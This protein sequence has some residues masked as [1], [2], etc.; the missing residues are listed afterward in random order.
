[1]FQSVVSQP[2]S[3]EAD[4]GFVLNTQKASCV[5]FQPA[6]L[7]NIIKEG[8]LSVLT[9]AWG[10]NPMRA[11][12]RLAITV[13]RR[14]A[15]PHL[16]KSF[17]VPN[18]PTSPHWLEHTQETGNSSSPATGRW[19]ASTVVPFVKASF[20]YTPMKGTLWA[21]LYIS[22][23]DM[24]KLNHAF[25]D[26]W[27]TPVLPI[28]HTRSPWPILYI[29]RWL[30][31][32]HALKTIHAKTMGSNSTLWF[33]INPKVWEYSIMCHFGCNLCTFS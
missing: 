33:T 4:S 15:S 22:S 23:M 1:M 14:L 2:F 11:A 7:L 8:K 13:V 21:I 18:L 29:G 20:R 30:K 10:M 28:L 12:C 25:S 3:F 32:W 5:R 17:S 9:L 27:R 24:P 16:L 19:S 31:V 26:S 6:F